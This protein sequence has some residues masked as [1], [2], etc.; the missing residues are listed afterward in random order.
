VK[1]AARRARNKLKRENLYQK[2][3]VRESRKASRRTTLGKSF[4][5]E[6]TGGVPGKKSCK[7]FQEA[8][9]SIANL[10]RSPVRRFQPKKRKKKKNKKRKRSLSEKKKNQI[11]REEGEKEGRCRERSSKGEKGRAKQCFCGSVGPAQHGE[12]ATAWDAPKNQISIR[13]RNVRL[14][15]PILTP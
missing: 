10:P 9:A 15:R 1:G 11:R 7:F 4:L 8:G 14:L 6:A 2:H 12:V 13:P 5:V 3:P